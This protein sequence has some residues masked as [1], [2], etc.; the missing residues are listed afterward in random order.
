[1]STDYADMIKRFSG[2][3]ELYNRFRPRLPDDLGH[4]LTQWAHMDSPDLVIDLGCGTG[5]STRYWAERA[6]QVIGIDPSGDMLQA[7]QAQ[8]Y[9]PN[10]SYR[11]GFGHQTGLPDHCADII[12]C[13][14]SLHWMEP[15]ST[16]AEIV[17][18]LRP[19]GVFAWLYFSEPVMTPWEVDQAHQ[20]FWQKSKA[21]DEARCVTRAVLRWPRAE[22]VR[23]MQAGFRWVCQLE[24]HQTGM[25]DAEQ[26]VGWV[27]T[28]G[29]VQSLFKLGATEADV[30]LD[31]FAR[32]AHR[33][34]GKAST[35]WYAS[36]QVSAG[37]K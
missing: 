11:Q 17:R 22:Y 2:F 13:C 23:C 7:A 33:I 31:E 32:T 10:V 3:A 9:L 35:P 37:I 29:H 8:T 19:G 20:L 16:F 24:L 21:A 4:L 30:G 15:G 36:V 14:D 18:V 1:M 34:L 6:K 25:S 26:L 5:L 28:Y 12:T 27:S